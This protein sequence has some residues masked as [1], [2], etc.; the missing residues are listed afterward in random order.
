MEKLVKAVAI[1]VVLFFV[2]LALTIGTR[3]DQN[4]IALLGGTTIGLLIAAPCTAIVTYLAFRGRNESTNPTWWPVQQHTQST[5][6]PPPSEAHVINNF[7]TTNSVIVNIPKG[8]PEAAWPM[9]IAEQLRI[10]PIKARQLVLSKAV[11]IHQS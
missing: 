5:A 9:L 10:S 4:M 11:E 2:V 8:T 6:P 1:A 7:Y 3:M